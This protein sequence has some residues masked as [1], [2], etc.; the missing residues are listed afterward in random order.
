MPASPRSINLYSSR[1]RPDEV[2]PELRNSIADRYWID[3]FFALTA[4][5]MCTV[6]LGLGTSLGFRWHGNPPGSEWIWMIPIG[7]LGLIGL[8][9]MHFWYERQRAFIRK[10]PIADAEIEDIQTLV[11]TTDHGV[12]HR[13]RL[14]VRYSPS[15]S[16]QSQATPIS[17]PVACVAST[18]VESESPAFTT[19]L[20][21]GG[22]VSVI[23]DPTEPKHVVVVEAEHEKAA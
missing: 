9:A 1:I 22:H 12:A 16:A 18:V 23:Y 8:F 4:V 20:A 14:V 11:E 10:M 3:E 21:R 2:T 13:H 19:E 7:L 6:L 17:E 15:R 5:V